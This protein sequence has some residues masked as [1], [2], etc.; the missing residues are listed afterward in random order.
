MGVTVLI[1]P[2]EFGGHPCPGVSPFPRYKRRHDCKNVEF[3]P[4]AKWTTYSDKHKPLH[5][6]YFRIVLVW[7]VLV[8]LDSR[9][10][11]AKRRIFGGDHRNL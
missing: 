11:V 6:S 4:R 2:F 9:F 10:I 5:Q 8:E 3:R 1:R 7:I